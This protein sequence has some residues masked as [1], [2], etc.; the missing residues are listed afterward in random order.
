MEILFGGGENE[1][2]DLIAGQMTATAGAF[3]AAYAR[4]AFGPTNPGGGLAAS[5]LVKHRFQGA[6]KAYLD[7]QPAGDKDFHYAYRWVGSGGFLSG[8][9]GFQMFDSS[10][11][12]KPFLRYVSSAAGGIWQS[13][14]DGSA[15]T[16]YPSSE[17][18]QPNVPTQYALRVK[19][20]P[21]L[22]R[23]EVYI[24]G[25]LW[26]SSV[27]GD[28]TGWCVGSPSQVQLTIPN[29]NGIAYYS[30]V[31]AAAAST[32]LAG[33]SLHTIVLVNEGALADWSGLVGNVNELQEDQATVISTG[34]PDT[35]ESFVPDAL[36]ALPDGIMI[37]ALIFSGK[38]R[39]TA[40][41]PQN[42]EGFL[43]IGG[44]NYTKPQ[45]AAGLV[46]DTL[47]FIWEKDPRAPGTDDITEAMLAATEPGMTA[48]A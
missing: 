35:D 4:G 22:G 25:S 1:A 13:S 16:S 9:A 10:P 41:A 11:T 14:S 28:T 12:P 36:P 38:W 17:I 44:V 45:Q 32:P 43:R 27:P 31:M 5:L 8:L 47:Q 33:L 20:H 48:K 7:A 42:V 29:S 6:L 23:F 3:R 40:G 19:I 2:L 24:N 21:T 39:T 46:A 30:E 18:A 26:F 37:R 15:W 34:V